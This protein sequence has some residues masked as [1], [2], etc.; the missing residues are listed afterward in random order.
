MS[1][2]YWNRFLI[3]VSIYKYISENYSEVFYIYLSLGAGMPSLPMKSMTR[4]LDL[5]E[6]G[7]GHGITPSILFKFLNYF[8]AHI[9]TI[10][11]G[12][13]AQYPLLNL[14]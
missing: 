12:F 3:I 13:V 11:L 7:T 10:F 8:S 1:L 14:Y 5:T 2:H 9:L 6:S 4:T